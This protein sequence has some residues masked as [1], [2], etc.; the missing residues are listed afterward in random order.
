[1]SKKKAKRKKPGAKPSP[2]PQPNRGGRITSKPALTKKELR[3]RAAKKSNGAVVCAS[4]SEDSEESAAKEQARSVELCNKEGPPQKRARSTSRFRNTKSRSQTPCRE[5]YPSPYRALQ[6]RSP[7]PKVQSRSRRRSLSRQR[8]GQK[9]NR[10]RSRS[11]LN[12]RITD[13]SVASS[14]SPHRS[15][16]S[17]PARAN[18]AESVQFVGS[19]QKATLSEQQSAMVP[20]PSLPRDHV[21]AE[22]TDSTGMVSH[23]EFKSSELDDVSMATPTRLPADK[24]DVVYL[25]KLK[26][27][28][29]WNDEKVS[30]EMQRVFPEIS[31]FAK[32]IRN[33]G[34]MLYHFQYDSDVRHIGDF[35]W[36]K[37]IDDTL[38]FGGVGNSRKGFLTP[39]ETLNRTV[40]FKV[41]EGTKPEWVERT[42]EKEG[43]HDCV[44]KEI[45]KPRRGRQVMKVILRSEEAASRIVHEGVQLSQ[46][47]RLTEPVFWTMESENRLCGMCLR[48]HD[49]RRPCPR[50]SICHFCSQIH[51]GRCTEL[52][53]S[54]VNCGGRHS[55]HS[56]RCRYKHDL[57]R[58]FSQRTGLPLP[59][60]VRLG[61]ADMSP[62]HVIE[63]QS[64]A[65][66]VGSSRRQGPKPAVPRQ[67]WVPKQV[68]P[69]AAQGVESSQCNHARDGVS[70]REVREIVQTSVAGR[71]ESISNTLTT[72]STLMSQVLSLLTVISGEQIAQ[73]I[74]GESAPLQSR[75]V[76]PK[77]DRNLRANVRSPP[78]QHQQPQAAQR[79]MERVQQTGH[80]ENSEDKPDTASRNDVA[81]IE[82]GSLNSQLLGAVELLEKLKAQFLNLNKKQ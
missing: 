44:A 78:A 38:P 63:G 15:R 11:P 4:E 41:F 67:V 37:E 59:R 24:C 53:P 6:L 74:T 75:Q 80:L 72:L 51:E 28:G 9:T 31:C 65:E 21:S 14:V 10:D 54:C 73:K 42:L 57:Y 71:F 5:R 7:S 58:A 69:N 32:C 34:I 49:A 26:N 82:D 62:A 16:G 29:V 30:R 13:G 33:G 79:P 3:A 40:R 50:R 20:Q 19:A 77:S 52:V 81:T 60:F 17:S 56:I 22:T 46:N 18:S 76:P 27:P 64:F 25:N 61:R 55:A 23:D 12:G 47:D 39:I 70:A 2:Q 45:G 8:G 1:M 36:E 35:D 43:F 48:L 66:A 68:Q